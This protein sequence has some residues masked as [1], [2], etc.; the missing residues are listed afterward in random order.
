M[1]KIMLVSIILVVLLTSLATAT[2]LKGTIYNSDLE[3][4]TNVLIEIDTTPAQQYLSKDGNYAFQLQPGR[5]NLT[6]TKGLDLVNEEINVVS[7][8]EFVFD[9][10]LLPDFTEENEL[11]QESEENYFAGDGEV[12]NENEG[13]DYAGWRYYL[14]GMIILVLLVRLFWFRKKYGSLRKYKQKMKAE[15][16][17]TVEEHRKELEAE[18]GYLDRTL[19]IIKKHDGRIY[20]KELRQEMLDLSEAKVSLLITELEHKGKIEKIKKGR[21]NVIILKENI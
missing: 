13:K 20:Q 3:V 16:R 14:A 21:G 4:E 5:Y 1:K 17:K 6:A 2:T 7:E 9:L 19:E 8:G 18:P 15:Q 10:F 11:W 12:K